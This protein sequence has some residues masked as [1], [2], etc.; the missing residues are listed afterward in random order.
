MLTK[1]LPVFFATALSTCNLQ[2][3][4]ELTKYVNDKCI[5]KIEDMR[6]QVTTNCNNLQQSGLD[7][8]LPLGKHTLKIKNE[9]KSCDLKLSVV[10]N[11]PPTIY[12]IRG[13]PNLINGN[14]KW[15]HVNF[16]FKKFENCCNV[17]CNIT[18][19]SYE[20]YDLECPQKKSDSSD[21]RLLGKSKDSDSSENNDDCSKSRKQSYIVGDRTVK[22]CA[23]KKTGYRKYKVKGMCY[24]QNNLFSSKYTTVVSYGKKCNKPDPQC[25]YGIIGNDNTCCPLT[26]GECGGSGCGSRPGGENMCCSSKILEENKSCNTNNA[27]C[28]LKEN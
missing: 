21:R 22:L 1:I 2:C 14:N 26:C 16:H 4:S 23:T 15:Q 12:T 13:E 18:H 11:M 5:Y 28:L 24:D 19:V 6:T 8:Y 7:G 25:T 27:P 3:P 9:Y 10:D 17:F 20:D